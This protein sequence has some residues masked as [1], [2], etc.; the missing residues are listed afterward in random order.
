[1]AST[2]STN[3]T[4]IVAGNWKMNTTL[5]EARELAGALVEP[6]SELAAVDT[7]LCPPFISLAA[8]RDAIA[9][10]RVALGA[11]NCH[12][13]T[14]GAFTGEIA[15]SMLAA[16][17]CRFVILGHSE[18]RQYFGETDEGVARKVKAVLGQGLIPIVCVGEDLRQNEAG[19][20]ERVV[21]TQVRG[22]LDALTPDQVAGCVI[23]YEPVWAIGTGRAAS[24]AGANATIGFI[25]RTI[26][27]IAGAAA[28]AGVRIQYG[29]SVTPANAAEL[30]GQPEIDGALVGGASLKAPDFVAICRAAAGPAL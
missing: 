5:A 28:G 9:G 19:E 26:G 6:L 4:P 12:F 29:G 21:G 25:R 20:T 18:R 16:L 7:V 24:A 11:Q 1:M 10:S 3:R 15:P 13:E 8:V 27:E 2:V 23:A 17:G 30:F 22:A 14:K